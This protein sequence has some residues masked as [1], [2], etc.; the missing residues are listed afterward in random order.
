M[1]SCFEKINEV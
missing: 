1:I